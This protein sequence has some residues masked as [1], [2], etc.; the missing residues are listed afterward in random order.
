MTKLRAI[1]FGG[2][3]RNIPDDV[4][5]ALDFYHVEQSSKS[6][7]PTACP[8]A[9]CVILIAKFSRKAMAVAARDMAKKRKIPFVSAR[10]GNYIIDELINQKLIDKPAKEVAI[11]EEVEPVKEEVHEE[12][13]VQVLAPAKKEPEGTGLSPDD[14]WDLYGQK[15]IETLR[16]A[17]KPGEKI[18]EDD[19]LALFQVEGGV[20]LPAIDAIELLPELS[21]RG[22]I[23]NVKGKTWKLA[24]AITMDDGADLDAP[25]DNEEVDAVLQEPEAEQ[26]ELKVPVSEKK[27]GVLYWAMMIGRLP[28]GVYET[29]HSI[30]AMARLHKEFVGLNGGPIADS[31]GTKVIPA[32]MELGIVVEENG[33]YRVRNSD[34]NPLTLRDGVDV[35]KPSK[36]VHKEYKGIPKSFT[37]GES[38]GHRMFLAKMLAGVP[39]K[40]YGSVQA[41]WTEARRYKE[42][43]TFDGSDLSNYY[44]YEILRLAQKIGT[45]YQYNSGYKIKPDP[46]IKLTYSNGTAEP[47]P[48]SPA[49][50]IKKKPNSEQD[51]V[52]M[53]NQHF[54]GSIP[55]LD[56]YTLPARVLKRMIPEK[57]WQS[58]WCQCIARIASMPH[59]DEA[60]TL[61]GKF[62]TM[63]L[64]RMAYDVLSKFPIEMLAPFLK[65]EP[66]DQELTCM[67][68][69]DKFI[70]SI[71]EWK[72]LQDKFKDE[73]VLPKRCQKCRDKRK[74]F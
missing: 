50:P 44:G 56:R 14:L 43:K 3:D 26:E 65:D 61:N 57:Y 59:P 70:V 71:Q 74:D 66:K 1:V 64:D 72:Y 53:V 5:E 51:I 16:S 27:G 22:V 38:K 45:V 40:I 47:V 67:D 24:S 34:H 2:E 10:T 9:K 33:K 37:S 29:K 46:S 32:A 6:M 21:M 13:V 23:L 60:L 11:A 54:G 7:K 42:F 17:L 8:D 73:A 19:L 48:E 49:Q 30:W 25:E 28:D 15:A 31:Y 55:T 63:E 41:I 39:E 35:N 62:S 36:G 69:M 52:A 58:L 12:E 4:R 68:C 18:A 20:G